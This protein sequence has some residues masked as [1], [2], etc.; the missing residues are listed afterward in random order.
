VWPDAVE[1]ELMNDDGE[2]ESIAGL[3]AVGSAQGLADEFWCEVLG[4]RKAT[5]IRAICGPYLHRVTVDERHECRRRDECIRLV[6]IADD[7]AGTVNESHRLC[8][9][10]S[11]LYD[12]AIGEPGKF[13]RPP[14][15]VEC[16]ADGP[17]LGSKSGHRKANKS[18]GRF[19]QQIVGP[20]H[21]DVARA[22]RRR[23]LNHHLHLLPTISI[24][25]VVD[26][27]CNIGLAHH[28]MDARLAAAA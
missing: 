17:R 21:G 9:V 23:T 18:S 22:Q 3:G 1:E 8:E 19:E 25:P 2:R 11:R 16:R 27:R 26:L 4:L 7:V 14:S 15:R 24:S 10:R 20:S 5:P 12:I 28:L 6:H 13:Y